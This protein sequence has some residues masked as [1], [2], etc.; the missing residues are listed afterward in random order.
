[1]FYRSFDLK[2]MARQDPAEAA[3]NQGQD[4]GSSGSG[5]WNPAHTIA[6]DYTR[7]SS[8]TERIS[9]AYADGYK[10]GQENK[11]KS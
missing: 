1:M 5:Y 7:S 8:E 4:D 6:N 2:S 3:N 11:P 10:N 9:Q